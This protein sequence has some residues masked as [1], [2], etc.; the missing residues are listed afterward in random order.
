MDSKLIKK[1]QVASAARTGVSISSAFR[2]ERGLI[3]GDK[4]PLRN[5]KTRHDPFAEVWDSLIRPQL[6]KHPNLLSITLLEQLQEKFPEEYPDKL[7]RTLQRRIKKWKIMNGPS[8]DVI[9]HQEHVPG[10]MGISDFTTLKGVTITIVGQDFPHIL[11]HFRL[12][13]SGWSFMKVIQ[14]GESYT[15]L[16]NGL[17]EALWRLGAVPKEHRTD[18]LSAAF[19]NLNAEEASDTTTN[20]EEF[21]KHYNI[22]PTRNNKGVAHENGSIESPHGHI[23]RRIEQALLLRES[24]NFKDAREYQVFIDGVVAS[25]N[26]R[27]AKEA[28]F[29][30]GYLQKLPSYKTTDF[31]EMVV[32]VHSS[33]TVEIKNVT[34]SVPS[35]LCRETLRAHIYHDRIDL[36]FGCEKVFELARVYGRNGARKKVIDYRHVIHALRKKPQAFRYSQIRLELLPSEEFRSIWKHVDM[37]MKPRVSCKFIVSLLYLADEYDCEA[38]VADHVIR[39]IHEQKP[40]SITEIEQKYRGK[41]ANGIPDMEVTQHS[42]QDYDSS[43]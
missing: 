20:Y 27:N 6:E 14:G 23:K 41:S 13:Y 38:A 29:E 8:K 19:K 2:V 10:R 9:F 33:S 32:K 15:A 26:R 5:W 1:T 42:L 36:Y 30:K 7:Q 11:Y 3:T 4:P 31:T 24:N 18:S 12:A 35:K 21:C 43:G 22:E 25:H 17:Q 16:A 34:Y 40:L 28:E 37:T 39:L